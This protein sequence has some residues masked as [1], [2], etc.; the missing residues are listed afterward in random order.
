MTA[1]FCLGILL[2]CFCSLWIPSEGSE[3]LQEY[4]NSYFALTTAGFSFGHLIRDLWMLLRLPILVFLL[5]FTVFGVLLIPVA[6]SGK[7]FLLS[8][9][10]SSFVRCFGWKGEAAALL[11]FGW[12]AMIEMAVLLALAAESWTVAQKQDQRERGRYEKRWDMGQTLVCFCLLAVLAAVQ[13]LCNGLMKQLLQMILDG[14]W[15]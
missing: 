12:S 4:L 9:A 1:A 8:F 15:G 10:F 6:V 2:G 3:A 13:M 7:G 14:C 11:L 5:R